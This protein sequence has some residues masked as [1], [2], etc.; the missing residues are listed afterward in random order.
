MMMSPFESTV[1]SFV[2][3][4][5]VAFFIVMA[6][7]T[8]ADAP[9]SP[10]PTTPLLQPRILSTIGVMFTQQAEYTRLGRVLSGVQT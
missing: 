2:C 4:A 6:A 8:T 5:C 7:R 10:Q 1:C 9:P 3:I